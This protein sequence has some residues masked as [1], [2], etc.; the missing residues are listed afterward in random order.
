M[1]IGDL[2]YW[3]INEFKI[4]FKGVIMVNVVFV[5]GI[6][7]NFLFIIVMLSK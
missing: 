2:R 3:Y 6:G 5:I 1:K 4:F 7:L